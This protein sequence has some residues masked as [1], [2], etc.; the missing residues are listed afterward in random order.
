MML[1]PWM[2][3]TS[4]R[5]MEIVWLPFYEVVWLTILIWS[6]FFLSATL[7][8]S[9]LEFVHVSKQTIFS[10]ASLHIRHEVYIH[11]QPTPMEDREEVVRSQRATWEQERIVLR[12]IRASTKYRRRPIYLRK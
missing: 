11:W 9:M 1:S 10:L 3:F 12:S 4:V 5:C 8:N 7:D 2:K 6:S